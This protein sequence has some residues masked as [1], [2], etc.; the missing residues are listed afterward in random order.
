MA[1][2]LANQ[3]RDRPEIDVRRN[4][5]RADQRSALGLELR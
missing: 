5:M 1:R 3:R 4:R 2:A